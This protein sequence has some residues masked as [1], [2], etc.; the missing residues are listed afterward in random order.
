[1]N[2][3]TMPIIA[4]GKPITIGTVTIHPLYNPG[5]HLQ[6]PVK[7]GGSIQVTERPTADV[8]TLTA[9]NIDQQPVL[10]LE[11]EI[12]NGGFQDR[13]LNASVIL[14]AG[15]S[16]E[17]PVSCVE[18][19]RWS[20]NSD[21]QRDGFRATRRVRR[22]T[23]TGVDSNLRN[24]GKRRSDQS[25]VWETVHHELNRL[26]VQHP[27]GSMAGVRQLDAGPIQNLAQQGPLPNQ[28]GVAISHGRRVVSAE[29]FGSPELLASAWQGIMNSAFLDAPSHVRGTPS[30]TK[31]LRFIDRWFSAQAVRS[32]GVGLGE[33]H[34]ARAERLVAQSLL[35][36]DMIVHASAFALVA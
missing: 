25:A 33:E 27:T 13:I 2:P 8:P 10:L 7:L 29:L 5:R 32:D 1:M 31:V 9:T 35:M 14:P 34:R 21:F 28:I 15:A 23:Q 20:G 12:V 11:G 30:A 36:S 17:L 18:H 24:Y 16:V 4:I 19:A 3:T 6:T 22:T 26:S